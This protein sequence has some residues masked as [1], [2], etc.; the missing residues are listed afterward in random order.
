MCL[1]SGK[2]S[3]PLSLPLPLPLL[4]LPVTPRP[5]LQLSSRGRYVYP[6]CRHISAQ[7]SPVADCRQR[8]SPADRAGVSSLLGSRA[9]TVTRPVSC[10]RRL[11]QAHERRSG[12]RGGR[13]SGYPLDRP[14]RACRLTAAPYQPPPPLTAGVN[15]TTPAAGRSPLQIK[16]VFLLEAQ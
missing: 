2:Y 3:P 13:Q 12:A 10:R 5:G 11:S 1:V 15:D 16:S 7:S 9:L 4:A 6:V 8:V 14:D